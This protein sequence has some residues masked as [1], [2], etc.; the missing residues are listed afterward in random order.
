MSRT[1]IIAD[2]LTAI[3]NA[4]K[5]KKDYVDIAINSV[6]KSI[7]EILKKENYIENFQVVDSK[8]NKMRIYLKYDANKNA[9]ITDIK[10]ISR[11]GLKIYVNKNKIPVVLRG[12][13][14]AILSTSS[15]IITNREAKDKGVGGEVICSVY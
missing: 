2:V 3:R 8:Y 1:D 12:Q 14:I 5:V 9:A 13:G 10:R 15:G 7:L 4:S 11:P 6:I